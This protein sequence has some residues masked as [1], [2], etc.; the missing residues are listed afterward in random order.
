[1]IYADPTIQDREDGYTVLHIA[2]DNSSDDDVTELVK[3]IV[4][5]YKDRLYLP[6]LQL[7]LA[8]C[9]HGLLSVAGY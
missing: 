2:C 1:M 3:L 4:D 6:C 9:R 5:R 8:Y 7:Q